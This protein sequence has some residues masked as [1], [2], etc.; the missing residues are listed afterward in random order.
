[1]DFVRITE[2]AATPKEAVIKSIPLLNDRTYRNFWVFVWEV[3]PRFVWVDCTSG[4]YS[5]AVSE[6]PSDPPAPEEFEL[7]PE[8]WFGS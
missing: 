6:S 4:S 2:K 1:M 3:P 8:I 5:Y 7:A